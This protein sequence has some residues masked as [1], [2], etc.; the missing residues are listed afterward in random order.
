MVCYAVDSKNSL[1]NA[2]GRWIEEASKL[3]HA[4]IGSPT[5]GSLQIRH[6]SNRIPTIFVGTKKDMRYELSETDNSEEIVDFAAAEQV[7]G[8]HS[9]YPVLECSAKTKEVRGL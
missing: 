7:A 3:L 4:L 2:K 8:D 1:D 9:E 5:L 6:F